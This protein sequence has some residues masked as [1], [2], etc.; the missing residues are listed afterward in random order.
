MQIETEMI[1]SQSAPSFLGSVILGLVPLGPGIG[2][3]SGG[4]ICEVWCF[5]TPKGQTISGQGG[6]GVLIT[7]GQIQFQGQDHIF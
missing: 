2:G 3:S 4:L 5:S 6:I 7:V 1:V